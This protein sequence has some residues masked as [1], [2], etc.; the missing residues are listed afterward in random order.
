MIFMLAVFSPLVAVASEGGEDQHLQDRFFGEDFDPSCAEQNPSFLAR[1]IARAIAG[2]GDFIA[3]R[4]GIKDPLMLIFQ[5]HTRPEVRYTPLEHCPHMG[6]V[7]GGGEEVLL[8]GADADKFWVKP[9]NLI[10]YTFTPQEFQV[11]DT[12]FSALRAIFPYFLILGI[13]YAGFVAIT[14]KS[15]EDVLGQKSVTIGLLFAPVILYLGPHLLEPLFWLNKIIIETVASAMGDIVNQPWLSVFF[16]PDNVNLGMALLSLV[17]VIAAVLLNFQYTVR[18]IMIGILI[19]MLPIIAISAISPHTRKTF[20]VWFSELC[21]NIFLQAAHAIVYGVFV[22]FMFIPPGTEGDPTTTLPPVFVGLAMLL[23][24]NSMAQLVR[25][26]FG[27]PSA[28]GGMLGAAGGAVGVGSMLAMGKML[29]GMGGWAKKDGRSVEEKTQDAKNVSPDESEPG[30]AG[31]GDSGAQTGIA[32]SGTP[33]DTG[34]MATSSA[35]NNAVKEPALPEPTFF[36][37]LREGEY[38]T[39]IGGFA[40]NA[41]RTTAIGGAAVVGG[42]FLGAAAGPAGL[43]VGVAGGAMIGKAGVAGVEKGAGYVVQHQKNQ[44]EENRR[45]IGE[46]EEAMREEDEVG[47]ARDEREVR[48]MS[49]AELGAEA[50]ET[51]YEKW[52]KK[53]EKK[54]IFGTPEFWEWEKLR[55]RDEL[56]DDKNWGF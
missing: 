17:A 25:T 53:Q 42:A 21:A 26:M 33:I 16:I 41:A 31:G 7:I 2:I 1:N 15:T 8:V 44:L 10:A 27:L 51:K 19:L 29:G 30:M 20:G 37:R 38:N 14:A 9:A 36:K 50:T 52:M 11:I 18:K 55:V 54:E 39:Q 45:Q 49:E 5:R 35:N 12:F 4:L 13:L 48:R 28:G 47:K 23:G 32:A 24:L 43:G 56:N 40:K 3:Q 22:V 46:T 6:H 34:G